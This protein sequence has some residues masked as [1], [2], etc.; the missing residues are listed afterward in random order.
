MEKAAVVAQKIA[1]LVKAAHPLSYVTHAVERIDAQ[2][3]IDASPSAVRA[4]LLA[5][6]GPTSD[7]VHLDFIKA[8]LKELS[9]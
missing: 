7:F 5:H 2:R 3:A 9:R 4:Q 6:Y 1:R 8:A